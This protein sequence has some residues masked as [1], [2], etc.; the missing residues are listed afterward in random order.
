MQTGDG[1]VFC[2]SSYRGAIKAVIEAVFKIQQALIS[3]DKK[4]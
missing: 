4:S 2:H 1:P 3:V